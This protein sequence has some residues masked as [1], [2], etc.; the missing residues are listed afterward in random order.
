MGENPLLAAA[1]AALAVGG[2]YHI[3]NK[4]DLAHDLNIKFEKDIDTLNED[5][6]LWSLCNQYFTPIMKLPGVGER[7]E[8]LYGYIDELL[9]IVRALRKGE[10]PTYVD[11]SIARSAAKCA[12]T[13]FGQIKNLITKD[14]GVLSRLLMFE[15][16]FS[17]MVNNNSMKVFQMT[18]KIPFPHIKK[19]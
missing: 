11:R 16:T 4:I 2:Y 12:I 6:D 8:E 3:K 17:K 13:T 5:H 9:L 15:E 10:P 14:A 18:Q 7:V 19:P 1:G